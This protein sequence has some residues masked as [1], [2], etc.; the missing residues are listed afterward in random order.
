MNYE[1]YNDVSVTLDF[2]EFQFKSIG[3]KEVISKII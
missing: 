1:K 3:P 2:L